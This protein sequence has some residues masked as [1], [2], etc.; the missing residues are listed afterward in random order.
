[1]QHDCILTGRWVLH[2][3]MKGRYRMRG[4]G[5]VERLCSKC[6]RWKNLAAFYPAYT[7]H[8]VVAS[9]CRK[10]RSDRYM[11]KTYGTVEGHGYVEWN[12]V[13]IFYSELRRRRRQ[14]WVSRLTGIRAPVLW[15]LEHKPPRRV[16]KRTARALIEAL[17][18][19]R[20]EDRERSLHTRTQQGSTS[21]SRR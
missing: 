9:E 11:L 1:M 2:G 15:R 17:A 10:C 16:L 19:A 21:V 13:V 18:I 6:R 7:R 3:A 20:E 4:T 5:D 12:K 8:R 14:I